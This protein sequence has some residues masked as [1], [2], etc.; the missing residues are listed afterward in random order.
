TDAI[1]LVCGE[2]RIGY[3]EL[4]RRANQLA[5]LLYQQGVRPEVSVGVCLEPSVEMVISIL[6]ILKAGGV[7]VPIDPYYPLE[8]KSHIV[9]DSALCLVLTRESLV[10]EMSST[11]T[12]FLCLDSQWQELCACNEECPRQILEG[13]NLAY[14]I[15][16]SGSTGKP[17]GV[18]L[19]HLGWS[20]LAQAQIEAF[21][22]EASDRVLQFAS[23]S[24]DAS[25]SEIGMAL[26]CGA[27][28]ILIAQGTLPMGE[29]LIESL[30]REV[31]T[32][33][34]LPRSVFAMLPLE[35]LT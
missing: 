23:A 3:G 2:E 19:T 8:R 10:E 33:V 14:V 25:I 26:A 31:I 1:A 16:T 22:V 12:Q 7:Y 13:D 5:Q 32:N 17:K 21:Q 24:F 30:K 34:T 9:E 27:Q 18:M 4:D 15:Y 35:P 28:L 29:E 11:S 6:G 20:N